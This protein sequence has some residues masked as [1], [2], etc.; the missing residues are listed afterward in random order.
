MYQTELLEPLKHSPQD[1]TFFARLDAQLNKVNAFFKLKEG[2]N[3]ARAGM[4]EKQMVA[5]LNMQ[6]TLARR[7]LDSH[8]FSPLPRDIED[9]KSQGESKTNP[10]DSINHWRSFLWN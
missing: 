3:I 2:D 4:L 8:N 5:L 10:H 1:K 7:G 9:P 6:E